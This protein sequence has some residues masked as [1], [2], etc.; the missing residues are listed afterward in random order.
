MSEEPITAVSAPQPRRHP[1]RTRIAI[2]LVGSGLIALCVWMG[3]QWSARSLLEQGRLGEAEVTLQRLRRFV[4]WDESA[5]QLLA[6]SYRR[7]NA[8]TDWTSLT[9]AWSRWRPGSILLGRERELMRAHSGALE[10]DTQAQLNRLLTAGADAND[11]A[12]AFF[13]GYLARQDLIQAQRILDAWNLELGREPDAR[14]YAAILA[15]QSG[16]AVDAARLLNEL[17]TRW[18]H[19]ELARLTLGELLRQSHQVKAAL[20][21]FAD[22]VARTPERTEAWVGIV[23]TLR[24]L[25]QTTQAE[26]WL[27]R[28][29][30]PVRQWETAELALETGSPSDAAA[31][32][33]R[34]ELL[35]TGSLARMSAATAAALAGDQVT[36]RRLVE[37]DARFESLQKALRDQQI[38]VRL[39]PLDQQA[40]RQWRALR[41]EWDE[42]TRPHPAP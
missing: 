42:L 2:V 20:P 27:S 32:F 25:G 11:V 28:L 41:Q 13:R 34:A 5:W 14:F 17:L 33:E 30:E 26:A 21:H 29:P 18:P 7:R 15:Q 19:H 35:M 16:D 37:T 38:R 22:V 23:R 3:W 8:L 9:E 10:P 39:A 12:E 36:R 1:R 6:Q 4:P 24:E 31:G 40:E